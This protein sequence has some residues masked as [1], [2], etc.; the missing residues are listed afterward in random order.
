MAS[1]HLR[2]PA[3]LLLGSC[4]RAVVSAAR[5]GLAGGNSGEGDASWMLFAVVGFFVFSLCAGVCVFAWR[6][7]GDMDLLLPAAVRE[8]RKMPELRAEKATAADRKRV[9]LA[10]LAERRAERQNSLR[11]AADAADVEAALPGDTKGNTSAIDEEGSRQSSKVS[12]DPRSDSKGSKR[13]SSRRKSRGGDMQRNGLGE[14]DPRG[15]PPL[16]GKRSVARKSSRVSDV[17]SAGGSREPSPSPSPPSSRDA[18]RE[19]PKE[20]V[21]DQALA[22]ASDGRGS[23][24]QIMR[25]GIRGDDGDVVPSRGRARRSS[26]SSSSSSSSGSERNGSSASRGSR[27]RNS[28]GSREGST[29]AEIRRISVQKRSSDITDDLVSGAWTGTLLESGAPRLGKYSLNFH[30]DMKISGCMEGSSGSCSITGSYNPRSQQVSWVEQHPWGSVKVDGKVL[31]DGGTPRIEG[32]FEASDG[33]KGK[34][35]LC[36]S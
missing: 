32:G 33:G 13:S 9:A 14:G 19:P 15:R 18:S 12:Q 16:P 26:S 11:S 4:C 3:A 21:Q 5:G 34:L 2:L 7:R 8:K 27:A 30:R 17:N 25:G 20:R 22:R 23:V 35:D 31:R 10:E 36:P 24:S 6:N 29:N 28:S 1:L